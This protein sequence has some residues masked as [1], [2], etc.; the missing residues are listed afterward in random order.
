MAVTTTV[1]IG[2]SRLGAGVVPASGSCMR[3]VLPTTASGIVFRSEL[4]VAVVYQEASPVG[5]VSYGFSAG[6]TGAGTGAS[7]DGVPIKSPGGVIPSSLLAVN[8]ATSIYL[9]ATTGT[10]VSIVLL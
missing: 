1:T 4:G 8:N 9:T 7:T 5:V 10:P 2:D 6:V 3:V